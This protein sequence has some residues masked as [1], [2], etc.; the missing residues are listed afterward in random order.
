MAPLRRL[1]RDRNGGAAV[2]ATFMLAVGLLFAGLALD[3]GNVRRERAQ[4][5]LSADVAAHTAIAALARGERPEDVRDAAIASVEWNTPAASNGN[6]ILDPDADVLLLHYDDATGVLAEEKPV[7]AIQVRLRRS[8]AGG[9]AIPTF[10]LGFVGL[11]AWNVTTS[12]L[13]ALVQ[14]RSCSNAEGIFA[15]GDIVLSA[16]SAF[17]AGTCLHSQAAIDP[18]ESAT[19][20]EGA[21]MSLPNLADCGEPCDD[22]SHPGV[23][24]AKSAANLIMPETAEYIAA[25][26]EGFSQAEVKLPEEALFFATR[27]LAADLSPVEEVHFDM[28]VLKT[29][30][31]VHLTPLEFSQMRAFP[32]GLTYVVDC[33]IGGQPLEVQ[34]YG[35]PVLLKDMALVTNCAVSFDPLVRVEGALILTTAAGQTAG[36][37]ALTVQQGAVAGDAAP[38]CDAGNQAMLMA[39]GR[40]DLAP[41][42]LA[43]D[44]A[45]VAGGD[46][47]VPAATGVDLHQGVALHAGGK[48]QIAGAHEFQSCGRPSDAVLPVLN[49]IR[50]IMMTPKGSAA[51]P[52][53]PLPK[54]APDLPGEAVAPLEQDSEPMAGVEGGAAPDTRVVSAEAPDLTAPLSEQQTDPT[55]W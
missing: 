25:L 45:V 19:F 51:P 24:A 32:S 38:G 21:R 40:I 10:L 49:V 1:W 11:D 14:T 42:F 33:G 8:T 30:D 39:V 9:N 47:T 43:S 55:S 50:E 16:P 34:A 26:Y 37:P 52:P 22:V 41:G 36:E 6:L 48:V 18:G 28:G 46:L 2:F 35:E 53:A 4:L 3:V 7:N 15:H 23:G 20:A 5:Q 44:V 29:G 54:V 17:G 31:T 13:A 12:S 27:P